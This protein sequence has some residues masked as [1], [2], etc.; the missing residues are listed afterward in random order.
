MAGTLICSTGDDY[1]KGLNIRWRITLSTFT[2]GNPVI[3]ILQNLF[4]LKSLWTINYPLSLPNLIFLLQVE[5][6]CVNHLINCSLESTEEFISMEFRFTL[7][8]NGMH[9]AFQ[10]LHMVLEVI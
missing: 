2:N 3:S 8:D 7:R 9:G 5:L 6:F 10:L 1:A 4:G